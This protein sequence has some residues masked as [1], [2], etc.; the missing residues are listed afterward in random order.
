MAFR[1]PFSPSPVPPAY[2]FGSGSLGSAQAVIPSPSIHSGSTTAGASKDAPASVTGVRRVG[3]NTLSRAGTTLSRSSL[4]LGAGGLPGPAAS[5][6]SWAAPPA[7]PTSTSASQGP[8]RSVAL[9]TA[10]P[11]AASAS[12]IS[13]ASLRTGLAASAASVLQ[14]SSRAAWRAKIDANFGVP[15][16]PP[17]QQPVATGRVPA[18]GFT[19]DSQRSSVSSADSGADTPPGSGSGG[20]AARAGWSGQDRGA[21]VR[22]QEGGHPKAS[23]P[24]KV[25][26]RVSAP[27]YHSSSKVVAA[28]GHLFNQHVHDL[29]RDTGFSRRDLY[30]VFI[31]FKALCAMSSTPTGVDRETL[32]CCIPLL[33]IEDHDF[34][35]RVFAVLDFDGSG[36]IEWD[37][38]L[39]AMSAMEEGSREKRAEFLFRVYDE[40]DDGAITA[41][42]FSK[43]FVASLGSAGQDSIADDPY[44]LEVAGYFVKK[45]FEDMDGEGTTF[46]TVKSVLRYLAKHPEITDVYGL[47]GRS[48]P[49]T[50]KNTRPCDD[51]STIH[52]PRQV[53]SPLRRTVGASGH[54]SPTP[55]PTVSDVIVPANASRNYTAATQ[56]Q[57][58]LELLIF[59]R[60]LLHQPQLSNRRRCL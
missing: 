12:A 56:I 17:L 45:L 47:F 53:T 24:R 25:Q 50:F 57:S 40:N 3:G 23:R 2:Q 10:A 18:S 55:K 51:P 39:E 16:L 9:S 27:S 54:A 26:S 38:F 14:G 29:C 43:F 7:V 36:Q 59:P 46:I 33:G 13:A 5:T 32:R 35:R 41:Q 8:S 60:H 31:T 28:Q 20:E 44:V 49:E 22:G 1:V 52:T 19:S 4:D 37:E 6:L 58:R 48:F 30:R 11:A 42:E 21:A 34:T 15:P